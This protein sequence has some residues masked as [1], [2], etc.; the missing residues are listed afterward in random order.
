MKKKELTITQFAKMGNRARNKSLSAA[1][2]KEIARRAAKV[3]W[4]KYRDAEKEE[5]TNARHEI[6]TSS[7]THHE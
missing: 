6:S 1:Q 7:S 3:R 4:A 5:V 2:R